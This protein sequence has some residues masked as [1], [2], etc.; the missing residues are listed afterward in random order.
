MARLYAYVSSFI[1]K[2]R[3]I[4]D[5][6]LGSWS[7]K[8][9]DSYSACDYRHNSDDDQTEMNMSNYLFDEYSKLLFNTLQDCVVC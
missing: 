7:D 5:I 3:G 6:A 9:A 4:A 8:S 2:V 1:F